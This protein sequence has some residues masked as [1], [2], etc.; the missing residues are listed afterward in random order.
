VPVV[1]GYQGVRDDGELVTLGR[2]GSDTSAVFLAAALGAAEC[3]IVTD[4]DGVYD[5]D[6]RHV[7]GARRFAALS[8][9]EL[10]GICDGGAQVVHPEAARR[11]AAAGLVL[12]VHH[13]RAPLGICGG[14]LVTSGAVA[15]VA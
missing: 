1:T 8:H 2:G 12:R 3:R 10:L 5:A 4:V 14:T 15:E 13:Y 6:P 11:A 7:P 9:A